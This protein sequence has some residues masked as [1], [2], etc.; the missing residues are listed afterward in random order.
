MKIKRFYIRNSFA[1]FTDQWLTAHADMRFPQSAET[2]KS[3][4][5]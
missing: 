5:L 4:H 1:L 3:M 2:A